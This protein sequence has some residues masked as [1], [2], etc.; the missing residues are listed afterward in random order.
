MMTTYRDLLPRLGGYLSHK[1][2]LHLPRMELFLQELARRET[3]YFEQR[4]AD[5]QEPL[6]A[7]PGYRDH[8]YKVRHQVCS[9]GTVCLGLNYPA[10]VRIA[11]GCCCVRGY[12]EL[13]Y[14]SLVA[15]IT[16]LVLCSIDQVWD[17]TW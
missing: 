9:V 13:C 12:A 15:T 10:A 3:L 5:E 1:Y 11:T 2:S 14:C 17:R 8:Y 7:G 4:G 6:Y 16:F